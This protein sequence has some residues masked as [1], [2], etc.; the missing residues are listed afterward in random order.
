M[1]GASFHGR[2]LVR[3]LSEGLMVDT[4][5][6]PGQNNTMVSTVARP[7][8]AVS[9]AMDASLTSPPASDSTTNANATR[10]DNQKS[11]DG[12]HADGLE[13]LIESFNNMTISPPRRPRRNMFESQ[14]KITQYFTRSFKS[15][16]STDGRKSHKGVKATISKNCK[17]LGDCHLNK[18][19]QSQSNSA[20]SQ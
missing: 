3:R 18:N 2:T 10:D 14:Q 7:L 8:V 19:S 17:L 15:K 13:D 6:M 20:F 4:N 9:N 5:V 11:G 12:D 1:P 16:S